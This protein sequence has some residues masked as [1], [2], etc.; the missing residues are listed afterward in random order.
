[1]RTILHVIPSLAHGS[2]ATQLTLL[3]TGLPRDRFQVRIC[4]LGR[5]SPLAR[6]LHAARLAV[7]VLAWNRTLDL[8]ALG[9]LRRLI[10]AWQPDVLHFWRGSFRLAGLA[11]SRGRSRIVV[12][13]PFGPCAGKPAQ[14]R[15]DRWLLG[16][17]DRVAARGPAEDEQYRRLGLAAEKIARVPLGVGLDQETKARSPRP[18]IGGEEL[19][20]TAPFVLGVGPLEPGK[21]F[22][23]AVWAM[24]ILR[25]LFPDLHL[26]LIG[27]GPDRERLS[28]FAHATEVGGRV[29]LVG[30]QEDLAP[31]LAHCT[32][33]WVPS[34]QA[35]GR[36]SALEAMAAGRP[37]VASRLP[38][39]AEIVAD[40]VTGFLI[41]PGDKKAL[42]RQTRLL[43][44]DADLG[45]RLGDAGRRRAAEH[46]GVTP[47]VEGYASIYA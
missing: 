28:A 40:G 30:P 14:G 22:H 32:A 23:D 3:S 6:P 27:D 1:M 11:A 41:A 21:G 17:A 25:F 9:R 16:R 47:M 37:V 26:V 18:R 12:S 45:R 33:V 46:F 31:W 13:A 44:D 8:P 15:L 29:H 20:E 19:P 7:E 38:A 2:A 34:R 43:L 10:H 24:G 5:G 4:V 36:Q 39:L 42:A 35:C